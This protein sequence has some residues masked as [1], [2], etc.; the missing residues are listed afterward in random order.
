MKTE[1]ELEAMDILELSNQLIY[2]RHQMNK[3]L[4]QKFFQEL[5]I[6]EYMALHL[7]SQMHQE[8][9]RERIY[10]KEL[11][12]K[13]HMTIRMKSKLAQNLKDR[14]LVIWSHDGNGSEGT[15]M[16]LTE[17]GRELLTRQEK[18]MKEYFEKVI[19]RFGKE[20]LIQMLELMKALDEAIDLE[21]SDQEE[22][23]E[24]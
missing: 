3:S 14:G 21:F 5:N 19:G 16:I 4:T 2:Q 1:K 24:A 12:D 17:F 10:L 22:L 11:A 15:Y 8:Q 9:K 23:Q 6:P 13:M 20:K 18:V 7:V